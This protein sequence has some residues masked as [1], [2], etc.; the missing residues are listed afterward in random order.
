MCGE[1]DHGA[2]HLPAPVDDGA[3]GWLLL[4]T[5]QTARCATAPTMVGRATYRRRASRPP[6]YLFFRAAMPFAPAPPR[7][8]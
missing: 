7:A 3:T 5:R 4:Q 2:D 6:K 1:D 8:G